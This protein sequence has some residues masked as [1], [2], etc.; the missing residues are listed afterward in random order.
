[1]ILPR[2]ATLSKAGGAVTDRL[3]IDILYLIKG[4]KI[5]VSEK[6]LCLIKK[7]ME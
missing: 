4:R 3:K 6:V 2:M 5:V 1:M 7:F